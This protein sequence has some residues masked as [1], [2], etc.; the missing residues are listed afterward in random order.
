[1]NKRVCLI[2]LVLISILVLS[3][4]TAKGNE[5][6]DIKE[7]TNGDNTTSGGNS[8]EEQ[9]QE[10]DETI[11]SLEKDKEALEN[12]VKELEETLQKSEQKKETTDDSLLRRALDV[13]KL[14]K[15]KDMETL[16]KYVH[17]TK[18]VRFSPYDYIDLKVHKVFKRDEVANLNKNTNVYTWGSYDG[19]GEPIE[20]KFSDYYGK[21]V[22]DVDFANP[23]MIGNNTIIGKGNTISNLKEVYPKGQFVEFYFS[24]IDPKYEGIDWRSLK[25]VFEQQDGQWYL[26]GIIHSQWTI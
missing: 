16:S 22:Y 20:L 24:G 4:C 11:A 18:G 5:T 10:K 8:L 9:L 19:S 13:I 15:N 2:V 12:K 1:M 25:L 7:T 17:P 14:I 6:T 3:A 26:V 21:F 23:H